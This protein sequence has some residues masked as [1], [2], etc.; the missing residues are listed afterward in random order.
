MLDRCNEGSFSETLK[1]K[2]LV[3]LAEGLGRAE[4]TSTRTNLISKVLRKLGGSG[5]IPYW[6]ETLEFR[7]R[8]EDRPRSLQMV[9][10]F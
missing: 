3:L 7:R 5:R 6:S 10:I 4:T 9:E 1:Y 8:R 2:F